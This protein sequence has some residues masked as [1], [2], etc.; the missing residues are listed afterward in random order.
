MKISAERKIHKQMH[1]YGVC[2][3]ETGMQFEY[4]HRLR[5]KRIQIGEECRVKRT[6]LSCSRESNQT[7]GSSASSKRCSAKSDPQNGVIVED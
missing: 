6:R 5:K 4:F 3:D 7:T 1:S 2:V